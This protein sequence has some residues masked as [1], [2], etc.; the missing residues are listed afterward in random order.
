MFF[1]LSLADLSL[2]RSATGIATSHAVVVLP[3]KDSTG[4]CRAK[5]PHFSALPLLKTLLF[6]LGP[7]QKT[8][9]SKLYNSLSV[10][11]DLGRS[12]GFSFLKNIRFFVIFSSKPLFV[13]F[14]WGAALKSPIFSEGP[15]SKHPPPPFLNPVRLIYT[16]FMFDYPIQGVTCIPGVHMQQSEGPMDTVFA[17]L[18]DLD[19]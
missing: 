2:S 1:S 6:R 9:F 15:L 5:A 16:N 18:E 3:Y 14:P 13:F 10:F 11:S 4:M 12:K 7:L 17:M 8:L 19:L